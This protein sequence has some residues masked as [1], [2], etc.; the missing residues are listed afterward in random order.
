MIEAAE[1]IVID[2]ADRQ[3]S[4]AVRASWGKEAHLAAFAPVE[5][6]IFFHDAQRRRA[7]FGQSFGKTDRM[8]KFPQ[9]TTAD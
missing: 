9:E 4:P 3:Q 6:E 1:T 8:P 2:A 5:R 7:G